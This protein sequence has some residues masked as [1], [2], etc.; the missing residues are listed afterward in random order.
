MHGASLTR[1][2]EPR[3]NRHQ[4]AMAYWKD[5][6]PRPSSS[7]QHVLRRA[8]LV[9]EQLC[10]L[11]ERLLFSVY[12]RQK[13]GMLRSTLNT[14]SIR[15]THKPDRADAPGPQRRLIGAPAAAD[16]VVQRAME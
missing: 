6:Q 15:I 12:L 2:K 9:I 10:R 8:V 5:T 16:H 4:H 7:R 3:Q 14:S 1:I 11:K 13:V